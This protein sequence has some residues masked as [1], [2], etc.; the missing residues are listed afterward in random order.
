MAWGND[1]VNPFRGVRVISKNW[2]EVKFWFKED[3]WGWDG[4]AK[5]RK[6][7]EE[8]FEILRCL[9]VL[10]LLND[11]NEILFIEFKVINIERI[12]DES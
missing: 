1:Q 9:M 5:F 4:N 11:H 2:F 8:V 3:F 10:R 7:P 6:G 12:H